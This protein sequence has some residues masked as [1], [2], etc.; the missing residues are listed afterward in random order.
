MDH[1]LHFDPD[2]VVCSDDEDLRVLGRP[3]LG[4]NQQSHRVS[5]EQKRRNHRIMAARRNNDHSSDSET[6][7][8]VHRIKDLTTDT[9]DSSTSKDGEAREEVKLVKLDPTEIGMSL[10]Y[11]ELYSGKED[12]V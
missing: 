1:F 12:K 2:A 6:D 10:G 9:P 4:L 8:V 7:I 11:K 3:R 5:R